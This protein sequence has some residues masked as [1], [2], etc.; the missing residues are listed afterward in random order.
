MREARA[1]VRGTVQVNAMHV[2][3]R[4][5][6]LLVRGIAA[7]A[8]GVITLLAP[9]ISLYALLLLYGAYALVD[10]VFNLVMAGRGAARGRR[11]GA[12]L[13]EGLVSVAA[14]IV[15]FAWPGITTL[16]LV[17][18]VAAWALVTGVAEIAAAIRLRKQIRHEWLLGT[19]GVLSIAF[20]I[21]IAMFP[22]AGALALV[23]WIGAYA[24]VFGGLLIALA[25]RLR[26]WR[27][28]GD[29]DVSA[30]GMPAPARR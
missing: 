13:F 1:G 30:T 4:W 23:L 7:V 8:F 22:G 20:G 5:W 11:W 15:A 29:R 9:G 25:F 6:V 2:A 28:P 12:F 10:G 16:A 18:L 24:L 27:G 3:E 21:A 19:A 26:T 17:F 14:G